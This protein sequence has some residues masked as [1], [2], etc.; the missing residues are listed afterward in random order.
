MTDDEIDA[1]QSWND[2]QRKAE[3]IGSD[4]T[5]ERL[6]RLED[7]LKQPMAPEDSAMVQRE[8]IRLAS[9]LRRKRLA[10]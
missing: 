4:D 3:P 6:Q 9:A 7:A 2:Q 5:W 10:A 8:W 1:A